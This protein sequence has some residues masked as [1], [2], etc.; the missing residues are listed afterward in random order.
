MQ[1]STELNTRTLRYDGVSIVP[2]EYV[3][4]L[5]L[6][7]LTPKQ[8][9]LS[10]TD[11]ETERFNAIASEQEQ[12][13]QATD[14][15]IELD[16]G[17][18]LPPEYLAL[19]VVEHVSAVFQERLPALEYGTAQTELAI[20]RVAQELSEFERRGLNDLLRVIIYV[21]ARFKETGQ[22]YGVGRGSS[23]A[24]FVL[25]LLGLHVVDPI[26]FNVP[27]EEFMHD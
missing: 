11:E 25:F 1:Q 15:P 16:F 8:L 23:C 24:S 14:E 19:D 9:R 26:K 3:A 17:W 10:G 21:L 12:L 7:G 4:D 20:N 5:L 6:R 18:R 13:L 22:V 2:A 27:L